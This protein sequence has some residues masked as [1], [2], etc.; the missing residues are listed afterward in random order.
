[1]LSRQDGE[2]VW[3]CPAQWDCPEQRRQRLIHFASRKALDI[4]G[5]GEK[6]IDA[7]LEHQAIKD[8]SDFYQL[9]RDELLKLPRMGPKRAWNMYSLRFA[10][11]RA[12][13]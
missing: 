10:H 2:A 3:R 13:P 4:D 1:M 7:L 12:D 11:R 6:I 8:P 9:A 5:L